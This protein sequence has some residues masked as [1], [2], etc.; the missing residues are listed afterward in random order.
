MGG[1]SAVD[2]LVAALGG[3]VE[4]VL[5]SREYPMRREPGGVRRFGEAKPLVTGTGTALAVREAA[6]AL[7]KAVAA[8]PSVRLRLSGEVHELLAVLTAGR[9]LLHLA[10]PPRDYPRDGGFGVDLYLHVYTGHL[11]DTSAHGDQVATSQDQ[12]EPRRSRRWTPS[13]RADRHPVRGRRA[14]PGGSR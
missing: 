13:E 14:L 8:E 7:P 6:V 5:A 12:E 1:R 11:P 3:L 4:L 9:E 2:R 10:L